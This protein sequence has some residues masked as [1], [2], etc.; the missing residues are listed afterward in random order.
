MIAAS[1]QEALAF[2]RSEIARLRVEPIDL[3]GCKVLM[4]EPDGGRRFA[5]YLIAKLA[6]AQ[7]HHLERALSD[8]VERRWDLA[9][10]ALRELIEDCDRQGREL[11]D[12]LAWYRDVLAGG[13]SAK[14][15]G[16]Q[17]APQVLRDIALA[18]ILTRLVEEF[19]LLPMESDSGAKGRSA[20]AALTTAW[21]QERMPSLGYD[22]ME[23]IWN[24][25]GRGILSNE[26]TARLYG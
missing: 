19:G 13:W 20:C 26:A 7:P 14:R 2:A 23:G 24:R 12:E 11:P 15:K 16:R 8:A 1:Y 3:F 4:F 17:K 25:W 9:D 21:T 5:V 6:S 10:L 22:R 18:I